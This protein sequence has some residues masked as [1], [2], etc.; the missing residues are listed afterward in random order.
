MR[1]I[2]LKEQKHLL[3][4]LSRQLFYAGISS[5]DEICYGS[6]SSSEKAGNEYRYLAKVME[7][8][9]KDI[10]DAFNQEIRKAEADKLRAKANA[11]ERGEHETS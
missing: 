1:Q 8:L 11:I 5:A 10:I 3:E 7:A 9:P 2:N 6:I 4:V